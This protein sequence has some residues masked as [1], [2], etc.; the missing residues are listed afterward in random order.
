MEWNEWAFTYGWGSEDVV[1]LCCVVGCGVW[2]VEGIIRL[3]G[4]HF[5]WW[6]GVS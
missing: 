1:W 3:V 5:G 2:V 6:E 4:W